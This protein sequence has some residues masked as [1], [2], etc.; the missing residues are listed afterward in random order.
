MSRSW[1]IASTAKKS[2]CILSG[3]HQ[4]WNFIATRFML[5]TRKNTRHK[6]RRKIIKINNNF[7]MRNSFFAL[8]FRYTYFPPVKWSRRLRKS[9]KE[10]LW[11]YRRI[12]IRLF[13]LYILNSLQDPFFFFLFWYCNFHF[14]FIYD[15]NLS[16]Y[17]L[18]SQRK[19][20]DEKEEKHR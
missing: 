1:R 10:K 11:T 13:L 15:L 14:E 6:K 8:F 5:I 16:L 9:F 7:V 20:V 3:F 2:F 19:N 18:E 17:F 4:L 12:Y